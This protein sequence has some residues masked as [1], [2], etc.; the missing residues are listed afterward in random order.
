MSAIYPLARQRLLEHL[1][2]GTTPTGVGFF[3]VGVDSTYVYDAADEVV[4]DILGSSIVAAEV[5][6]TGE[7]VLPG[8]ILDA[9]DVLFTG[10]D[11]TDTIDAVIV[12]AKWSGGSLLFAYI[13]ESTDASLPQPIDGAQ[14]EIHWNASGIF[15]I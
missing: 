11:N 14:G 13:D 4:G 5:A 3:V 2:A 12:Y 10:L 1:L 15:R 6:L 7:T 8:G 9:D